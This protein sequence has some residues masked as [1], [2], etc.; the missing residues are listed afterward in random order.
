LLLVPV[1]T[2]SSQ[3]VPPHLDPGEP[4]VDAQQL[5]AERTE[6]HNGV[7]DLQGQPIAVKAGVDPK[8]ALPIRSAHVG[9]DKN[10]FSGHSWYTPPPPP[11]KKHVVAPRVV[12]RG[13]VA[14][15]LPYEL[16]GSFDQA[17]SPTMYFLAHDDRTYNVAVGDTLE[18]KYSVDSVRNGQ[19]M[20]TYLPLN[21]SQGLWLGEQK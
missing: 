15:P 11:P 2:A 18:G 6:A 9:V 21:T 20:F 16:L 8:T 3:I 5:R 14:P 19:L 4:N 12:K 13:P 1:L 7:A 17:G 10:I